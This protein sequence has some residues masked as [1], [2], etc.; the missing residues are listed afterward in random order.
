VQ[1]LSEAEIKD[2]LRLISSGYYCADPFEI[3]LKSLAHFQPPEEIS[4]LEYAVD[5]RKMLAGDGYTVNDWSL[6][7]TP[8]A[9]P[10]FA[11]LDND[12]Y[13][14][15]IIPKPARSGG[16]VIAETYL[17]KL[18]EFGP[19]A[20]CLWYLAGPR[21]VSDYATDVFN[22]MID[23]HAGVRAKLGSRLGSSGNTNTLKRFDNGKVQLLAIGKKT[24]TNRQAGLI[25]FDEPDS[26][27]PDF[28][29][30][31]LN[32]GK[33]RGRMLGNQ[34]KIFACSH[35]DLGWRGGIGQ[36][37]LASTMGILVMP[38]AEPECGAW[39]SPY[40]T[41]YWPDI[42][43][44]TLDYSKLPERSMIGDRIRVAGETARMICP[45]CG[46]ALTEA[47]RLS[48]IDN[49]RDLHKGQALGAHGP[50]GEP[51]E[52]ENFGL[53]WHALAVKQTS[54]RELAREVEEALE[55]HERTGK[56]EKIKTVMI[57][58]FGEAF[59]SIGDT[60]GL[61]AV[62]LRKRTAEMAEVETGPRGYRMGQVPPG[63][64]FITAQIDP[65]GKK[66]DV[67]F[68]GWDLQRRR[69]VIDRFTAKQRLHNDL[70]LELADQSSG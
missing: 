32:T 11:A 47:Q 19:F 44:Y 8:Y 33:Q 14:A 59:E 25:V 48:M 2:E 66:F 51:D 10:V 55:H 60:T 30:S 5:R 15:V 54:L 40:P 49:V 27:P 24:T 3:L 6:S 35:P 63:V 20:S 45:T 31:W 53:W 26:Y 38:C 58:T 43:R 42:P 41:K 39:A 4:S 36:G 50:E 28:R 22:P 34:L 17:M 29:S 37:W 12:K 23:I 21:E 57:R 68:T 69:W 7:L 64:K 13:R 67:M 61:D 56:S 16:T 9:K 52:N 1:I 70:V 46:S 18:I 65:G 62:A